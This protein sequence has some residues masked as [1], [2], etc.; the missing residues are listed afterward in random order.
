MALARNNKYSSEILSINM[1]GVGHGP[2]ICLESLD[3]HFKQIYDDIFL[4]SYAVLTSLFMW[5]AMRIAVCTLLLFLV[6]SSPSH[7][8]IV[9][10]F[11]AVPDL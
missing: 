10:T 8:I 6:I 9:N 7:L 11:N 5:R 1:D 3:I 4:L 2:L